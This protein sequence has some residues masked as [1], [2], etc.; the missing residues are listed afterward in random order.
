MLIDDEIDILHKVH[1]Y[2]G[3]MKLLNQLEF[4]LNCIKFENEY[5]N[6][7]LIYENEY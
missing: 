3:K 1:L 2:G 6:N 5:F 7:K 4:N